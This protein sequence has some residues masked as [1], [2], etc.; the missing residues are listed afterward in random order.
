MKQNIQKQIDYLLKIT[1][2]IGVIEHCKVDKPDYIEGY[3]TDDNA[4]ALQV[5]LKFKKQYPVLEKVLPIYF[6]FIKSANKKDGLYDDLNSDLTW[7]NDFEIN[8]E[9]YGRTLVA[10]GEMGNKDLFD[11]V[12]SSFNKK[13]SPYI[14]VVAQIILGLK[15]YKS[16]DIKIWADILVLQYAK[17][18]TIFWKWF[19]PII[20]Y[21]NGRL[22]MALLTAY[23][24]T[25][26]NRY[27]K[28]ALESL[29][30]LT[31]LI[32]DEKQDCFVFPGNKGWF[33]KYNNRAIFDQ[34][35]IEA[36]STTEAYSLAFLVTKDKKYKDLAMKSFAWYS[37]KNILKEN[38]IDK[39]T[40]GIYDGF[41]DKE[42]N[43]NQG[44]ES[45][46]SYLLASKE[47]ENII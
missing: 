39:K 36:G 15:Y 29:D 2:K 37:G 40:G 35:P 31:N 11:Q 19:E 21:D 45:V 27:L 14:R 5:C 33:T 26:D 32:F 23:Q 20:S 46:L 3:C 9:H 30:F 34:Q 41:S 1:D 6:K 44:A 22:P 47:I 17:E 18:R 25:N 42:V 13:L 7:K 43:K 10:L 28:V 4:R 24:V 16:E 38:M 12:Y 8:G